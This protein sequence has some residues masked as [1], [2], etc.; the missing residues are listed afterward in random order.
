MRL[1]IPSLVLT[2]APLLL[3]NAS[4]ANPTNVAPV[5]SVEVEATA[6]AVDAN[7]DVGTSTESVPD[8]LQVTASDS[9][10]DGRASEPWIRR[11]APERNMGEIGAYGGALFPAAEHELY[12]ERPDQPNQGYSDLGTAAGTFGA[13]VGY[14]PLRFFAMEVEGGA[15]GARTADDD[16]ATLWHVRGS[17]VGQL[18]LWSVVPFVLAGPGV[19]GVSSSSDALGR[20]AD[21]AFHFGGG[22]K[23]H[24]SRRA[25]IR[26]DVRDTLAAQRGIADGV[27]HSPEV[28]L[29][30]TLTLGRKRAPEE[31]PQAPGD[32]DRDGF[33]DPEDDCPRTPGVAPDGCP[34]PDSDADGFLDP[35]DK[36]PKVAGIAPDG[37]PA[38]DRD[39]DGFLDADDACPEEPGVEPDGCPLRDRD[40]DRILDPDDACP[41]AAET[42][43]GFD[44]TDGCPDELPKEV[45]AFSG[46]IDGI[47]FDVDRATIR[48]KSRAVL[49]RAVEVLKKHES[50]RIEVSG[51]TDST[52]GYDHNLELSADR[53]ASVRQYL[54]DHGV[55]ADRIVTRGAGPDEP[56][57]DNGSKDGRQKNRRIEF[58]ILAQ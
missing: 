29:S 52:G 25:Q 44:D 9:D 7:A 14:A 34:V 12:E 22:V 47:Y 35:D 2:T 20:D 11:W 57:A 54:L 48:S 3:G 42:R 4:A 17:V 50:I 45:E 21:A 56:I 1:V 51:H 49:D 38:L 19:L 28:L 33:I 10:A 58:R 13:R 26:L 5:A 32:L 55:E 39:R 18:G 6:D 8:D 36:C 24:A 27:G 53:S 37:C 16:R 15:A 30:T 23:I 31:K 40:G 41:D 46:V 43:N